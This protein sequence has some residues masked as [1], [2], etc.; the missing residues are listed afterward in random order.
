MNKDIYLIEGHGQELDVPFNTRFRIPKDTILVLFTKTAVPLLKY[1]ACRFNDYFVNKK[2][3][4]SLQDPIKYI[5]KIKKY[6][7]GD[8]RVY[9]EG[10][11]MPE[12]ETT[13][14]LDFTQKDGST[15][16]GKSGIYKNQNIPFIN[17]KKFKPI[18]N[19][20]Q[21]IN[22]HKLYYESNSNTTTTD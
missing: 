5:D 10:D 21:N 11:L 18:Y 3:K 14:L 17:R 20:D 1:N 15:I 12:L 13:V 7:D 2:N 4:E 9:K 8:I 19:Y 6:I 16:Y 22:P